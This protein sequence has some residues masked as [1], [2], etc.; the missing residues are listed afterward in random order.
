MRNALI[1]SLFWNMLC[2]K[3]LFPA[4]IN[5][6]K[7]S[8]I[9]AKTT[10]TQFESLQDYPCSIQ[11]PVLSDTSKFML[12]QNTK[13]E[14]VG[15][16]FPTT[17]E[18][19]P[20]S[21]LLP[22][23]ELKSKEPWEVY[24]APVGNLKLTAII[25]YIGPANV[26]AATER[27]MSYDPQIIL[28][29]G[30]AG[31]MN[32]SLMPG[33]VVLGKHYKILCSRPILAARLSLLLSNKAIRYLQEGEGVHVE[34]L[35]AQPDL[36]QIAKEASK[37]VAAKFPSWTAG[38]WPPGIEARAP[39]IIEGTIGSQ[40]GWTKG[41]E[42]L[43]YISQQFAVDSEDMESAYVAQIAAKH[44]VPFLAVRAISNNEYVASLEKS[45]IFPAVSAAAAR[46]SEVLF[47]MVQILARD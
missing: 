41:Q 40:D 9:L 38:G 39:R 47:K 29:G 43:E 46:A 17:L 27:L 37:T 32:P 22:T 35:D 44:R 2:V 24:S 23:L 5:A 18:L 8:C 6:L 30:S 26:A 31:A 25:S 34:Q 28:H 4:I 19:Q 11:D 7:R 45:E 33:D 13:V 3:Y 15:L 42:E 12:Y 10:V 21:D 36:L 16:V 20:F 1:D 14:R